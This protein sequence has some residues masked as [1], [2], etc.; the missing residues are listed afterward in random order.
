M[1]STDSHGHHGQSRTTRTVTDITDSHGHGQEICPC[2]LMPS[3]ANFDF[4]PW[5]KLNI[6]GVDL[7]WKRKKSKKFDTWFLD[8]LTRLAHQGN[9]EPKFFWRNRFLQG[10]FTQKAK[11]VL[12]VIKQIF[13]RLYPSSHDT[14]C[15]CTTSQEIKVE[16]GQLRY[17]SIELIQT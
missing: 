11:I 6:S 12:N 3:P 7:P 16:Q 2:N 1:D 5:K 4:C 8:L 10:R 13:F 14:T 17:Q 15:Q 9:I